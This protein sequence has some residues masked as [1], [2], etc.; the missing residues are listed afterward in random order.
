M[1]QVQQRILIPLALILLAAPAGAGRFF[2][3]DPLW[4]EPPQLPVATVHKRK[5]NEYFDFFQNTFFEPKKELRK[6][7]DIPPSQAV[8]TLGEVPDSAW[9]TNRI[10]TRKMSL[11]ELAAGPGESN[12]PS[13][14]APWKIVS[15]KNEG[16]TPGFVIEDSKGRTYFLKFDPKSN[17]EMASAA[18]VLGCKFFHD[19]GYNVPE[20][21]IVYFAR[22]QLQITPKTLITTRQGTDRPMQAQD[23]NDVMRKVSRDQDG[24]YR[25]M[26]SL[27]SPRRDRGAFPLL[28]S[29]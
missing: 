20:N 24:R 2:D 28:R 5:I 10:G 18:D 17:P 8:N 22:K 27:D 13:M 7:G 21:Y 9:F 11:K 12:P 14:E 6:H 1:V 25:G 4:R 15:A 23:V 29:A 26:A 16:V 19:L 3:D